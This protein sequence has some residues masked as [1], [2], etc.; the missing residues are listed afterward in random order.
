MK[1]K[2]IAQT[3]IEATTGDLLIIESEESAEYFLFSENN[4]QPDEKGVDGVVFTE[5][6][7]GISYVKIIPSSLPIKKGTLIDDIGIIREVITQEKIE[8]SF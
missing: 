8:I 2:R 3:D 1:F 4:K 6:K 7:T 5:L